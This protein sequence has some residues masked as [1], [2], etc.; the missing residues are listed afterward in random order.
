MIG[1]TI[2]NDGIEFEVIWDG[3]EG[4]IPPRDTKNIGFWTP[5]KRLY[6]KKSEYWTREKTPDS[7]A[8]QIVVLEGEPN[9]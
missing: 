4:L 2:V 6:N 5:P 7:I 1:D 8:N 3:G 9:E